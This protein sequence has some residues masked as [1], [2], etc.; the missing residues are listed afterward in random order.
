MSI[1]DKIKRGLGIA[2]QA[3][4]ATAVAWKVYQEVDKG[5]GGGKKTPVKKEIVDGIWKDRVLKEIGK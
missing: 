4:P 2:A 5:S 3:N 1:F